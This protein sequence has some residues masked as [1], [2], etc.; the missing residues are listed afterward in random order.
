MPKLIKKDY[1]LLGF[2]K[3][4]AKNK[5]YSAILENKKTKKLR[6][7]NF[8]HDKYENY[9]DITGL[10]LY[11]HLIHD[12]NKRRINFRKRFRRQFEKDKKYYTPLH[13]SWIYL[14]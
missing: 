8:G 14:W 7:I 10:D 4:N 3:S 2:K 1:N 6:K 11:P 13:F 9:R 12:D 5:M